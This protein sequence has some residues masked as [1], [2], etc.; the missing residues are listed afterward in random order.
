MAAQKNATPLADGVVAKQCA[1]R[2]LIPVR[3]RRVVKAVIEVSVLRG[4]LPYPVADWLI[5]EGGL[6]HV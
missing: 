1:E 6:R 4:W 2:D 3:A 5:Q